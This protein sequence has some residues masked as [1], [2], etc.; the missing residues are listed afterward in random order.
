[1]SRHQRTSLRKTRKD[2][3]LYQENICAKYM[4]NKWLTSRHL[5]SSYKPIIKINNL[6]QEGIILRHFTERY[7]P[8]A[9]N[10]AQQHQSLD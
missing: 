6:I 2:K 10:D 3:P 7:P 5:K 9:N 4:T 1:M 8:M